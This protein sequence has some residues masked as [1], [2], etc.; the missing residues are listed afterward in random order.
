VE[1]YILNIC[2]NLIELQ[3]WEIV[4][5]CSNWENNKEK[6][7]FI[8][9]IKVY[10]LSYQFKIS[11]TPLNFFWVPKI[12]K[13]L[14]IEKPDIVNGHTPVPFISDIGVRISKIKNIPFI[15]TYHNDLCGYNF[16]TILLSKLYYL[17]M[18]NRTLALSQRII[19]SNDFYSKGSPYLQ[20]YQNKIKVVSPGVDTDYLCNR[21]GEFI[22]ETYGLTDSKVILFVGQLNKE[23][24]H[25][26]LNVLFDAIQIICEQIKVK[27]I[28]IGEGNYLDFYKNLAA[29]KKISEYIIFSN[30]LNTDK[31]I[32]HYQSADLLV[33]PSYNRA[34]GFGMVLIEAQACGLPVIGTTVGGIP[35]AVVNGVTGILV[36][37]KNS[38][39]LAEAILI[40]LNDEQ[41]A[42][43]MGIAGS[44]R[45]RDKFTWDKSTEEFISI[46]NEVIKKT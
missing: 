45:V 20:K 46:I 37:P 9:G 14:N 22:K 1:N 25:K 31:L 12:F 34:E 7:E 21:R 5:V 26:G 27:L 13:I 4:V 38:E 17:F 19:V 36:P 28:V 44:N 30:R 40:I 33:L 3:K 24:Q 6:I 35:S 41:R 43:D 18:G 23:S 42:N 10:R 2:K 15:L 8:D 29:S 11:S 39:K 16:M 32:L